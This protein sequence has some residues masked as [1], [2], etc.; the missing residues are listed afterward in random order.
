MST[1]VSDESEKELDT[2]QKGFRR[3][4]F[5]SFTIGVPFCIFKLLFGLTAARIGAENNIFLV[6]FG[7]IIVVWA[8]ADLSINVSR[9]ILDLLHRPLPFECCIIAQL[10]HYIKNPMLFLAIDTLLTFMI[11]CYMLWSFWITRLSL[12]ESYLWFFATTLN[13]ISLSLVSVYNEI[14]FYRVNRT[15]PE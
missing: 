9:G 14:V 1:A 10:G 13:L 7:W 2:L 8:I 15:S 4:F 12:F 6:I 3:P 11:V 5:L